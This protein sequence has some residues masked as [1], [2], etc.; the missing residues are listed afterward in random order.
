MNKE[1][2]TIS[3]KIIDKY[4][5]LVLYFPISLKP[6]WTP[7]DCFEYICFFT[8]KLFVKTGLAYQYKNAG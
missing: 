2:C 1:T 7:Y 3:F 8:F 6:I 5:T 4:R